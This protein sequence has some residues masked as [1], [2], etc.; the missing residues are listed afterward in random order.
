MSLQRSF[1]RNSAKIIAAVGLAL[2]FVVQATTSTSV[3]NLT[4]LATQGGMPSETDPRAIVGPIINAAVGLVGMIIL[5]FMVYAG[6]TWMMAGGNS[7]K[8]EEAKTTIKNCI[9]G[10][11]ILL[12]AYSISAFVIN[13]ITGTK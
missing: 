11:F 2:P 13:A 8:V 3:K 4:D 10:L 1:L 5:V 9:I 12:L 7:D 6:Y